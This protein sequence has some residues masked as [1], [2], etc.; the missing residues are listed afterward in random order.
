[1]PLEGDHQAEV[2]DKSLSKYASLD[3][4]CK[5]SGYLSDTLGLAEMRVE[6]IHAPRGEIY[7]FRSAPLISLI[8]LVSRFA[9]QQVHT[10]AHTPR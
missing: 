10:G 6:I 5:K 4:E 2:A 8:S 3:L 7:T 9:V 1:M